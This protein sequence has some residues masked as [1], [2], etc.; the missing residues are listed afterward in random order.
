[1]SSASEQWNWGP[2]SGGEK[3]GTLVDLEFSNGLKLDQSEC[4]NSCFFFAFKTFEKNT[5]KRL[6]NVGINNRSYEH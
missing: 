6:L 5:E 1:M 4:Q 2:W 3:F